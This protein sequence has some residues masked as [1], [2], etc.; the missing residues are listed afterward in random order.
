MG[1]AV[2]GFKTLPE[3]QPDHKRNKCRAEDDHAYGSIAI[4]VRKE[5]LN[6]LNKDSAH[7]SKRQ[8][9]TKL[10]IHTIT[11]CEIHNSKDRLKFHVHKDARDV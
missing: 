7:V 3:V 1:A 5:T 9:L 4:K 6:L 11:M 2:T 8:L 10:S